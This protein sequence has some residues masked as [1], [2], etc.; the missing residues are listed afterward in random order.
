MQV[1][2]TEETEEREV[3]QQRIREF[4]E[5]WAS[6]D[7]TTLDGLLTSEYL[8]TDV[9]GQVLNREEWLAYA[10]AARPVST[11]GFED[12]KT[13]LYS[14]T[15]VVTGRN[16]IAGPLNSW[17]SNISIRFTQVWAKEK[18]EWKRAYFQATLISEPPTSE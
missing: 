8:H 16:V 6:S 15:A 1:P 5:A 9:R 13:K 11:M 17:E 12:V 2:A 4:G 10:R 18:G 7:V 14:D 3:L